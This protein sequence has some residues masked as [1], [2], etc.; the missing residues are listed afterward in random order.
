VLESAEGF[1]KSTAWRVLAGDE[2]FSDERI[3]GKE[4]RE[5]QEQLAGVWIHE[6]ADLAWLKRAEVEIVKAYASRQ[7]DIARPAYGYMVKKQKRHSI[8]IG[9][10]NSDQYL[11]SQTGNRRFWPMQV[12][13]AID[14]E[15]LKR[16]QLQLWGEAAHYQS[17]GES[18]VL[19]E[20]L[21]RKAADEQEERRVNDPWECALREIP[22]WVTIREYKDGFNRE[23]DVQI[24]YLD[25]NEDKVTA[26]D[27]L[28][29]ILKIL[30]G[31]QTTVHSMR[32]SNVMKHL[33]QRAVPPMLPW[34]QPGRNCRGLSR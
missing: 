27:L 23:K 17:Q 31:N 22:D 19:D 1:N 26:S 14:I 32:L 2:N 25:D 3:I 11:Q 4:S 5:V 28:E 6:N 21:W 29:H 10:T 24:I 18:L 7:T 20:K 12:T 8:E 15:K 34:T 30:P 13:K 16:D 33:R 9:T